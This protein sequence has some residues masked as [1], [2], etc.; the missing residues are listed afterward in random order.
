MLSRSSSISSCTATAVHHTGVTFEKENIERSSHAMNIE[1]GHQVEGRV[2][3]LITLSGQIHKPPQGRRQSLVAFSGEKIR[4]FLF[5]ICY[6][7][8]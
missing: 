5:F 4:L 3:S 6:Y 8:M 7:K 2:Q 1:R